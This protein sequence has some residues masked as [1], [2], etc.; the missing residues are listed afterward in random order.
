M[1]QASASLRI[2]KSVLQRAKAAGCPAFKGGRVDRVAVEKWLAEHADELDAGL[3][4]SLK[5][6]KLAPE[7]RKLK[8]LN[9]CNAGTVVEKADVCEAHSRCAARLQQFRIELETRLPSRLVGLADVA[10]ARAECRQIVDRIY[11]VFRGMAV[12]F[13]TL[14]KPAS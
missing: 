14:D 7:I 13:S 8:H 10:A 11:E 12:E 5:D 4:D 6:Q 2:P 3:G 1:S 9:D